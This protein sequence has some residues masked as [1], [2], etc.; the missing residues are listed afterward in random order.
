LSAIRQSSDSRPAAKGREAVMAHTILIVDDNPSIRRLLRSFLETKPDYEVCGE[1]EN[2]QV[3]LQ[4]VEV[5]RPDVVIL[6]WQMP[7]MDGLEAARHIAVTA[8]QTAILMLTMHGSEPLQR[9][10]LANGVKAV[11]SKTESVA[12]NLLA[13]LKKVCRQDSSRLAS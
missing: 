9:D 3:A 5:L 7:V 12:Q 8:P 1:A 2:G 4:K 13:A 11:L 6:D 10:A